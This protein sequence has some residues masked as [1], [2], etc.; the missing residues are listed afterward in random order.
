[1]YY[2]EY[3]DRDAYEVVDVIYHNSSITC[4]SDCMEDFEY[5]QDNYYHSEDDLTNCPECSSRMLSPE[6]YADELF[7]SEITGEHYCC[8][9]CKD[10]AELQ[11]KKD[12]WHY[13][14]FDQKYYEQDDILTTYNAWNEDKGVYET[15]TVNIDN[16]DVY[17]N[18]EILFRIG[19]QL[20]DEINELQSLPLDVK[21]VE[22]ALID[23]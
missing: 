9:K 6:Y 7:Y 21:V 20:Y 18:C 19:D 1:M 12:N 8:Q 15:K 5:F 13:C 11:F 3:H 23:A 14:D 10:A 17:V 2:D 22:E 16:V 4:D